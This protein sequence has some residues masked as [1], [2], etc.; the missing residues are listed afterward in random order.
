MSCVSLRL[1]TTQ[2]RS[3]TQSVSVHDVRV[4]L[5]ILFTV[6]P[7]NILP[8]IFVL[9]ASFVCIL[10]VVVDDDLLDLDLGV[11]DLGPRHDL[12]PS[13]GQSYFLSP[14]GPGSHLCCV[15]GSRCILETGSDDD[16]PFVEADL[17]L[18]Y[19]YSGGHL[20]TDLP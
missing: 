18:Q 13:S 16:L 14:S 20:T 2:F 19:S 12:L 6:L 5:Q 15:V 7:P 17:Y 8:C 4:I 3:M 9:H 1:L 10:L 11:V